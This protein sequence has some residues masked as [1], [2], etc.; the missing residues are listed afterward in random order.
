[1]LRTLTLKTKS[2]SWW[3]DNNYTLNKKIYFYIYSEIVV[4]D[5]TFNFT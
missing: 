4:I 3:S 1:M 5:S 2:N